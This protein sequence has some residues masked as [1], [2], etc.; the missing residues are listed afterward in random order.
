MK[1]D[2]GKKIVVPLTPLKDF[3]KLYFCL[4]GAFI[5][6]AETWKGGRERAAEVTA[7]GPQAG[8]NPGPPIKGE[9]LSIYGKSTF[10]SLSSTPAA[11]MKKVHQHFME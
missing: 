5:E 10:A 2:H 8:F 3:F 11:P 4:F 1:K 9:S 7:N 6:C